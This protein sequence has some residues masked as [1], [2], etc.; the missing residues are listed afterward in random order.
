[1]ISLTDLELY[2]SFFL[3]PSKVSKVTVTVTCR[4]IHILP[5]T[6]TYRGGIK[7]LSVY[8]CI[9]KI[10]NLAT[11][12]QAKVNIYTNKILYTY[13]QSISAGLYLTKMA[14]CF[15]SPRLNI[16][17]IPLDTLLFMFPVHTSCA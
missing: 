3:V 6:A 7:G 2:N 12:V 9:C 16:T 1:M 5:L 17:W 13:L 15:H 11:Y 8:A 4:C 10:L 14:A